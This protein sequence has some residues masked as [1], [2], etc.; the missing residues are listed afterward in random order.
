MNAILNSAVRL[1]LALKEETYRC[2]HCAKP[3]RGLGDGWCT[4]CLV[5]L[6]IVTDTRTNY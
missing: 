4:N 2:T 1:A 5:D 3:F 6:Y